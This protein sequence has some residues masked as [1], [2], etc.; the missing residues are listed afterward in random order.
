MKQ[1]DLKNIGVDELVAEYRASASAHG[2]ATVRGDYKTANGHHDRIA[3][4][5][6]E[7][8]SRGDEAK[9][10]LLRLLDDIDPHVRS[11]AAAHAL[12]FAPSRGESVLKRLASGGGLVGLNAAMTLEEWEKGTLTFP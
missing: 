1:I 7:L 6:R 10:E 12:E 2:V 11:W 9:G 4:I 5:Y 3:H 8:R